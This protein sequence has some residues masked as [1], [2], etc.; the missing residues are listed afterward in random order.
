MNAPARKLRG[1]V[2]KRA[3]GDARATNSCSATALALGGEVVSTRKNAPDGIVDTVLF[4][5]ADKE[6]R[7]DLGRG[8]FGL[9]VLG[10]ILLRVFGTS[11][12]VEG[13]GFVA[14]IAFVAVA[15][16]VVVLVVGWALRKG[17]DRAGRKK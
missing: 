7:K 9:G 5:I 1:K 4:L 13:I 12:V 16:V 14:G 6:S 10:F 2:F 8:I 3:N 17:W 15:L 11:R